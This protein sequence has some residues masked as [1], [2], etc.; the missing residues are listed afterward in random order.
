MVGPEKEPLAD[1][2]CTDARSAKIGRPEGVVRCFQ[3]SRYKVEPT[4]AVFRRNLFAKYD[5]RLTLSDE[6]EPYGP[7]VAVI[8][9]S[10]AFSCG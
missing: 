5:D 1:M 9:G 4:E 7:E 10:L 2:R 6:V 8:F 3:V